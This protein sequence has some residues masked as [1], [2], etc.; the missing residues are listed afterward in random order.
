MQ[1]GCQPKFMRLKCTKG[2]QNPQSHP[3]FPSNVQHMFKK[4]N[5][6]LLYN[7]AHRQTSIE[8]VCVFI[9]LS[10]PQCPIPS[11]IFRKAKQC[12]LLPG[13][14]L[15]GISGNC[16]R[17]PHKINQKGGKQVCMCVCGMGGGHIYWAGL[18]NIQEANSLDITQIIFRQMRNKQ[19]VNE[20]R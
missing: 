7:N 15:R 14:V 1:E 13:H 20:G 3:L 9:K 19:E 4:I 10:L 16:L 17:S 18:Q 8:C 11:Q 2:V 5:T 6:H 12:K